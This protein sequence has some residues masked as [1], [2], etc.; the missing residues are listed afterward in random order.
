ML[1]APDPTDDWDDLLPLA[2]F[3]INNSCHSSTGHTPFFLNSGQHPLN[4]LT[5][6]QLGN[7]Q[8]TAR[9]ARVRELPAVEA[10][11]TSISEA[12]HQ[13]KVN[14]KAA[15]DR[16][17]S[18]ADQHRRELEFSI[19]DKVLLSTKNL[20]LKTTG[21]RKL[22]PKYVGPFTVVERIGKVAYKL[23]LPPH[24]R[25]HPVFHVSILQPYRCDGR[26]QPPPVPVAVDGDLEYEVEDILQHR[27]TR[28]GTR[29][30]RSYLVKWLGYG[31]EHNTWEPERNLNCDELIAKYWKGKHATPH[32]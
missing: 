21:P 13:A 7:S 26:V 24:M 23:D 9:H 8:R 17:K 20:K 28:R 30:V 29:T 14:L 27:D 12:L 19:G 4:P 3:A 31:P 2:E 1:E 15:Q 22:F 32:A 6:G 11:V 25:C 16:Q 10:F 18:Y 5:L